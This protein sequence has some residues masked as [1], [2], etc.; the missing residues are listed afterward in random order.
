MKKKS[1]GIFILLLLSATPLWAQPEP[2]ELASFFSNPLQIL[3]GAV[4]FILLF[5]IYVMVKVAIMAIKK[6]NGGK[7]GPKITAIGTIIFTLSSTNSYAEGANAFSGSITSEALYVSL[8][9]IA[10][11]VFIIYYLYGL[12][13]RFSGMKSAKKSSEKWAKIWA[14]FQKSTPIENEGDIDLGHNYDGIRELD[15]PIPPWWRWAFFAT[16]LFGPIYLYRYHIAHSAPLQVEE[17]AIEIEEGEARK[18]EYLANSPNAIDENNIATMEGIQASAGAGV[19]AKNCVACHGA[20]GEGNAVGPN[21]TDAYWLHGGGL[22]NVF[23][24]VKYGWPEKG[25]KSWQAEM[26]SLEMAQVASY[27]ASLQGSNPANAK[28]AQ[29]EIWSEGGEASSDATVDSVVAE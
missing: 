1:I 4:A 5:V 20:A 29:G 24:S 26:S 18:E 6:N 10:I 22:V 25:M 8:C 2:S 12:I 15:N 3:L 23:K 9:V 27:V 17:L 19:F 7:N 11:E 14:S 16:I 13:R 21:L 28:E